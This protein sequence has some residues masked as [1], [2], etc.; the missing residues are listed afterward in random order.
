[1]AVGRD[2]R[3]QGVGLEPTWPRPAGAR[4]RRQRRI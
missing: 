3:L 1:M 2:R 4:A